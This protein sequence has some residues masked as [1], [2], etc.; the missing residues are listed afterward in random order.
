M[1]SVCEPDSSMFVAPDGV[2][3]GQRERQRVGAGAQIDDAVLARAIG[4]SGP[5]LFDEGRACGL[6]SDAWQHGARRVSDGSREGRLR[7]YGGREEEH[8][9]ERQTLEHGS[10]TER[11]SLHE[12]GALHAKARKS[13]HPLN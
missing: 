4:G 5:D 2:E 10:H 6:N 1:V 11:L 13:M 12:P 9:K 8:N 3:A 7:K